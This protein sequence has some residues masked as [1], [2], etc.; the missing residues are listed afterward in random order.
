MIMPVVVRIARPVLV[1]VLM[2][3][4]G[5]GAGLRQKGFQAALQLQ[6]QPLQ[7]ISQ[8]RIGE[9]AQ[10]L[11]TE[12]ERHMAVAEVIGGPQQLEGIGAAHQ[13]QRLRRR[14]HPHC[15]L[16]AGPGQPFAGLQG[17]AAGQLQHQLQAATAHPPAPQAGA[18]LGAERQ[19][20]GG[21]DRGG[22]GRRQVPAAEQQ[23]TGTGLLHGWPSLLC[24][25]PF[26]VWRLSGPRRPMQDTPE[27]WRAGAELHFQC[28]DGRTRHQGGATAPLKIQRAFER[29]DGRCELP[30]LH[31][32]GGLV[33]GDQLLL[34]AELEPGSRV[35]LT[36]VAAQK[37]YGTVGRSRRSPQGAWAC[38]Q[39]DFKLQANTDLEWLPQE[40]VIYGDGLY[41]QQVRVN[42]AP[43]AGWLGAEVVR[44]GR[45]AAGESLGAGRWRS[46]LE[47][48]RQEPGGG[49]EPGSGR[50]E[51]VDRLEL[52][53][54]SLLE[55]HGMAGQPVLGSLV[56]V[57]PRALAGAEL[58][59]LIE[60]CR[61]DRLG[62]EGRMACGAL[63]QGLVARYRG[64][65]S[66]A[67]RFWFTRLWARI[68]AVQGLA[69]PQ[70]PRVWPFQEAP[71]AGLDSAASE[72]AAND[73]GAR[74]AET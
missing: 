57:A 44:L 73:A 19:A 67:A 68:R 11:G 3:T 61:A 13:Q 41:E 9:Q 50:W 36:S 42:L 31:T 7:E 15:R 2:V 63:E 24:R 10:L 64:G 65:S 17:F 20:E 46:L 49:W 23:G 32:A 45:T 43:G 54:D 18:L 69:P 38:V 27:P 59:E 16:A 72:G 58:A 33:G 21:A 70:L 62:L 4:A 22:A 74:G 52:G 26:R 56:W 53:G 6:T 55:P 34:R 47:I 60:A 28:S 1:A 14:L 5:I 35:L 51:L 25:S 29:A 12:L 30:I 66:T 8:H 37:V 71:L 48:R 40:L 39:L